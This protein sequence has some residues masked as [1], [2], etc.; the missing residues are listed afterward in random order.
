MQSLKLF[1]GESAVHTVAAAPIAPMFTG[2]L[3]VESV[4]V[5]RRWEDVRI[6]MQ[7][8]DVRSYVCSVFMLPRVLIGH[9]TLQSITRSQHWNIV[10]YNYI[11][12]ESWEPI[13]SKWSKWLTS[14]ESAVPMYMPIF[15]T[16]L[17]T[18]AYVHMHLCTYVRMHSTVC[19]YI[20]YVS[21]AVS[22]VPTCYLQ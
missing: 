7:G 15:N 16:C 20:T 19:T 10:V 13:C 3:G 4:Q 21:C 11:H 8:I 14:H 2:W 18:S 5:V 12:E 9:C 6:C 1:P 17:C 22:A